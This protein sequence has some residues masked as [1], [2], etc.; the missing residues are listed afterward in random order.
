MFFP[1]VKN[2]ILDCI[3]PTYCLGCGRF[4]QSEAKTHLCPDC[5]NKIPINS[6]LFCPICLKRLVTENSNKCPHSDKK[7]P[8]DFLGIAVSY[9]NPLIQ[10]LIH[11]YKYSFA[12]EISWTLSEILIRYLEKS[13]RD[14]V[15][16]YCLIAVPLHRQRFNWRGFNQSEEIAKI[17]SQR[18]SLSLN[19]N[20]LIRQKKTAS[21]AGIKNPQKRKDNLQN[22]FVLKNPKLIKN[23]NIILLDDVFTSG[24]TMEAAAATL[25]SGGAK[26]IIGLVVAK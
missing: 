24:A 17:L 1:K 25:K 14:D 8:L 3:F 4:L 19:N 20:C 2:F 18:F 22:A 11:K 15:K 13:F 7:S 16:K 5:Q 6:G 12:K 23:K 9:E 10:E 21:Q 26:R